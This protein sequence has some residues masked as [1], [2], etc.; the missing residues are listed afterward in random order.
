MGMQVIDDW[1]DIKIDKKLGLHTIGTEIEK[2]SAGQEPQIKTRALDMAGS[3]YRKAEDLGFGRG[4]TKG[5][6]WVFRTLKELGKKNPKAGGSR[7]RLQ[8]I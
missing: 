6:E 3:Y 1:F 7:E 2:V 8:D 4:A 5:L